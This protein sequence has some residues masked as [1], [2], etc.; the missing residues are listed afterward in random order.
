MNH[1]RGV[2]ILARLTVD[3]SAKVQI[4]GVQIGD[5]PRPHRAEGVVAFGPHPL[6][7][8]LL[9]IA[10]RHVVGDRVAQDV[11]S[12]PGCGN[13]LAGPADHHGQFAFV[14]DRMGIGRQL[15]RGIGADD[16]GIGLEEDHRFLRRST[17]HLRG[18]RGVVLAHADH[19][20]GQDGGQQ[21]DVGQRPGPAGERRIAEWVLGDLPADGLARVTFDADE[22]DSIGT[23]DSAETHC[24]SVV[25]G[26]HEPSSTRC[27]F[28][29]WMPHASR[30]SL[31]EKLIQHHEMS[32]RRW[33]P[34]PSRP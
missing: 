27:G 28:C 9:L 10:R 5:D 13:I 34:C 31:S 15:D 23:G 30:V 11:L 3:F 20:A 16:R 19:F 25:P 26:Q 7:V 18:V 32:V 22:G 29:S 17:A 4:T 21:P 8:L 12:S 1:Q 6:A 24:L 2:G 14:M 33:R